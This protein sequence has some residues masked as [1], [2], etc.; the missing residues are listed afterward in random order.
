M[1]FGQV[2]W[3]LQLVLDLPCLLDQTYK[4]LHRNRRTLEMRWSWFHERIWEPDWDSP[5]Y[6]T[7]RFA[8]FDTLCTRCIFSR[9]LGSFPWRRK[10]SSSFNIHNKGLLNYFNLSLSLNYLVVAGFVVIWFLV[11]KR[12]YWQEH[13]TKR[14]TWKPRRSSPCAQ[15]AEANFTVSVQ[16]RIESDSA[17]VCGHQFYFG[18]IKWVS[19]RKAYYKIEE[20]SLVWR[21]K[22]TGDQCMDLLGFIY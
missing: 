22:R 1:K 13:T 17:V 15:N 5:D 8:L 6:G 3:N 20:S 12:L 7:Q 16:I 19:E 21:R 9:C 4:F 11:K 10:F 14:L 18:R 2:S